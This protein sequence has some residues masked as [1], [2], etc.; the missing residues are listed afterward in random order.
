MF[1]RMFVTMMCLAL[2]SLAFLARPAEAAARAARHPL[3]LIAYD[4]ATTQRGKWYCWGGTGSSCYDCSGL[5]YAAYR[6]VH[7]RL[8][9]T[10]YGMLHSG[11]LIRISHAHARPGDL[12]FFG[13]GHVELF[14]RA[15][16]TFGAHDTGTRI[17]WVRFNRY[18]HP[19]AYYRVKGAG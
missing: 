3:R 6:H 8:A 10:T 2:T 4:W 17:G 1:H 14:D 18:W 13:P 12:A 16:L 15:N 11:R 5:V 19:T 7:I 9:R